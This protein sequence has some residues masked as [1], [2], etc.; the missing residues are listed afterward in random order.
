M[1]KKA[2]YPDI[3]LQ[4]KILMLFLNLK[5]NLQMLNLNIVITY[6]NPTLLG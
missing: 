1:L 3:K 2:L 5:S 4:S 6:H